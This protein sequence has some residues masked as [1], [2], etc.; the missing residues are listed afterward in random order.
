MDYLYFPNYDNLLYNG[1]NNNTIINNSS[2]TLLNSNNVYSF[3][4]YLSFLFFSDMTLLLF[5]GKKA[6]WFQLHTL[7]N[8]IVSK[9]II[10]DVYNIITDPYNGYKLLD[11][12]IPSYFVFYLHFYHLIAFR[13]LTRYDY[14]HHILFI[15]LGVLPD[16]YFIKSNQKY[17][18]YIVCNGIPGIIEYGSLVLYKNNKIKLYNQKKLNTINYLLL[19]LPFCVLT[20]CFNYYGYKLNIIKD[21]FLVTFYLNFLVYFNGVFFTYLTFDSFYKY[22]Y[23]NNI[24]SIKIE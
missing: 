1:N 11:N 23:L 21:S 15:G 8:I 14:F 7:I 4:G 18:A 19:R 5:I 22:K 9:L 6:R 20:C 12:N 13:N 16:I 17:L 2:Y 10:K 3:L 24:N